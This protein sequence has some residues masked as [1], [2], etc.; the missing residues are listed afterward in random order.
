MSEDSDIFEDAK[1]DNDETEQAEPEMRRSTRIGG[2][3]QRLTYDQGF[4]QVRD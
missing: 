4:I 3:P 2:P 1:D